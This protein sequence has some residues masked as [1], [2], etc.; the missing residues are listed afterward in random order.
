MDHRQKPIESM[1]RVVE[2]M[3]WWLLPDVNAFAKL[4]QTGITEICMADG[5]TWR[6]SRFIPSL[7][8]Q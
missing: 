3:A 6:L 7:A 4:L 2:R 1:S 8:V 5:L